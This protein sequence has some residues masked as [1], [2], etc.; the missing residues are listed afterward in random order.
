MAKEIKT[1]A[2]LDRGK[3]F[4]H[5]QA[6]AVSSFTSGGIDDGCLD[7]SLWTSR[8]MKYC[9]VVGH[10]LALV[11][12]YG[13]KVPKEYHACHAE[14][15]LMAYFLWMHT[16][17]DGEFE[18]RN[19]DDDEEIWGNCDKIRDL[20]A[21]KPDATSMKK[22]IYSSKEPCLDCTKFRERIHKKTGI[23]F[24]LFFI[25]PIVTYTLGEEFLGFSSFF[26]PTPLELV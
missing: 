4:E 26:S 1:F 10:E 5:I 16:T 17:L 19:D 18:D 12:Q 3:P 2:F 8:V 9:K 24:N 21:C 6:A 23:L 11:D 20:D 14:K 22:D 7:R 13:R 15:Q 25:K